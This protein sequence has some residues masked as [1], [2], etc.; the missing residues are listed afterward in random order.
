MGCEE[1]NMFESTLSYI[2]KK[3][4]EE[5]AKSLVNSHWAKQLPQRANRVISV[6]KTGKCNEY[7]MK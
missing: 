2:A 5:V 4:W 1:W 3:K 6:F 7:G